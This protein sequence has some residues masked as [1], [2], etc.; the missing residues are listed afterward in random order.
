MRGMLPGRRLSPSRHGM[1]PV[2]DEG[3][4]FL[5][6]HDGE[7]TRIGFPENREFSRE[8]FE[9][10]SLISSLCGK[11]PLAKNIAEPVARMEGAPRL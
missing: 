4:E 8:V 11:A 5:H 6:S 2:E 1:S 9:T 10:I 7:Q 3:Y